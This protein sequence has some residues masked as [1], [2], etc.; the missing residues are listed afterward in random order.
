MHEALLLAAAFR[1]L[2]HEARP[3]FAWRCASVAD[4]LDH[5]LRRRFPA[6]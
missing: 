4:T 6:P 5:V 2:S 3:Q 1:R